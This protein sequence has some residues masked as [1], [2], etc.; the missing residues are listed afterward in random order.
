MEIKITGSDLTEK[1]ALFF[2][3]GILTLLWLKQKKIN[4]N[5]VTTETGFPGTLTCT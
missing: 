5:K 3:H 1:K 4:I 2:L